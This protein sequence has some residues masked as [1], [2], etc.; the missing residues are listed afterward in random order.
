MQ[1]W[2]INLMSS[3]GY[4]GIAFLMFLE[5]VFPP[6]PSELIMPLAGFTATG[7]GKLSLPLVIAAGTLGSLIG[8]LPLYY[9]GRVVGEERL[10]VWADKYGAWLTVS[11]DEVTHAREW[12]DQHGSKGILLGRVV[13]GVRSLVSIPAGMAKMNLGKFLL[14]TFFGTLA[15]TTLLGYLGSLLGKN[16]EAVSRYVGPVSYLVL[17]G[18]GL[19]IVYS[20]IR[21]KRHPK[22]PEG[23]P[24]AAG[25]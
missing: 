12:F 13:P 5:N 22:K 11:G 15:W 7:Q 21:R 3:W 19:Y 23:A 18:I 10:K 8:Q 16:Y 20:V 6:I 24:E 14:Y 25:A 2:I 17:G 4:L 1:D 9:L